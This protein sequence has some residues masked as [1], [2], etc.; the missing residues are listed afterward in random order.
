MWGYALLALFAGAMVPMQGAIN[1][2]LAREIGSTIWAATISGFLLTVLLA[3]VGLLVVRAGP[4][5][6]TLASLPWWGWFGFVCGAV[7][8][9]AT[10]ALAPRLGAATMVALLMAGQVIASVVLDHYG[11][12][13]L[14][15]QPVDLRRLAAAGLL[16][17]GAWLMHP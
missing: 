14:A 17:A 15:E 2:R 7:F 11:L 9:S 1:G 16:L 10:A 3:C 4:R 5:T 8:L 13:G 6:E 12:L